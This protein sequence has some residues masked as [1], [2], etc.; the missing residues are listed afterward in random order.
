MSCRISEVRISEDVLYNENPKQA[1]LLGNHQVG[2]VTRVAVFPED[3]FPGKRETN[4]SFPGKGFRI[5]LCNGKKSNLL[6]IS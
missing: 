3:I 1:I 6:F 5:R 2:V 4:V